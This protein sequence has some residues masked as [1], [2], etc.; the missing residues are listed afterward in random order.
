MKFWKSSIIFVSVAVLLLS[1]MAVSAETKTETD[2]TGDVFHW[3]ITETGFN[4][5]YSADK[6]NIDITEMSCDVSDGTITLSLT[7]AGTI[8]NSELITYVLYYNSENSSYSATY[9]NG[10]GY[11]YYSTSTGGGVGSAPVIVS[12]NTLSYTFDGNIE[13]PSDERSDL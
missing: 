1:S 4:W 11:S 10:E 7:V 5:E 12:G 9:S 8:E 2:A 13:D 3:Q 6:P